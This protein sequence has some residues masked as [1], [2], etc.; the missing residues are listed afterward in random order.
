MLPKWLRK[1]L[2]KTPLAWFQ[3]KR[4]KTR[5]AVALA[6]I[7]FADVLMFVQMG[8][9]DGLYDSVVAPYQVIQ[10]DL[11]IVSPA[12]ESLNVVKSFSR[13]RLYQAAAVEEVE[14]V[15]S[16]YIGRGEWRN[17]ES[18]LDRTIMIFGIDPTQPVFALPEVNQHLDDLKPLNRLMYDRAGRESLFGNVTGLLQQSNPLPVQVNDFEI[19]VIGTFALGASFAADGNAITSDSTFLRLFLQRQPNEIDVGVLKLKSGADI[20]QVQET[21]QVTLPEDVLVLT[22]AEFVAREKKYWSSESPI[23]FIFGFGTVIG[24]I[25]GTV[26]V[27]QI[28]YS[29][30]SEHLPEYATLKAMGYSDSYLVGI[31]IQEALILAF[32]GFVPGFIL[33]IGLYHI[34]QTATLL[35]VVMTLSRAVLVLCLTIAMCAAS[36]GIAMRKLQAADP[37]D[38][39]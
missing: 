24:F 4:E 33:S 37:A 2:R 28:L 1:Q 25:V 18:R 23:G 38:I 9:K 16:L 39:F 19:Q 10:G 31:L 34:T 17:P 35:P 5:L 12:F 36:G 3:V 8:L 27:Y 20:E 6:G 7:A 29:D 21:M 22:H 14:T 26:I 30:V 11:F 15:T 32:L 13:E